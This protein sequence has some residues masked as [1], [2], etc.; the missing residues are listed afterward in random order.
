MP[1]VFL[2]E[3]A[4]VI[5]KSNYMH[6]GTFQSHTGHFEY[7]VI[8]RSLLFSLCHLNLEADRVVW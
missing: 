7:L 5:T 4:A 1:Q 2:Q 6:Y 8:S 3:T